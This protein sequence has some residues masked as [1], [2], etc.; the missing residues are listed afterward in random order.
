MFTKIAFQHRSGF[1]AHQEGLQK[2]ESRQ[3][4]RHAEITPK[5]KLAF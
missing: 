2:E 1:D 4:S 5:N 3:S